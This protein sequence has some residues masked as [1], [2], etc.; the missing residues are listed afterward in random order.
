M[1]HRAAFG[2]FVA[3]L[4]ACSHRDAATPSAPRVADVAPSEPPVQM[5]GR[6]EIGMPGEQDDAG[7]QVTTLVVGT[8]LASASG[9]NIALALINDQAT[10]VDCGVFMRMGSSEGG[11]GWGLRFS[12]PESPYDGRPG[13]VNGMLLINHPAHGI[14]VMNAL[15]GPVTITRITQGAVEGDLQIVNARGDRY[16]RGHFVARR[17]PSTLTR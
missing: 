17:C 3:A 2:V 6:V 16:A 12:N 10:G 1:K 11:T 9:T 4:C 14:G 13:V 15:P 7:L 8:A 5:S